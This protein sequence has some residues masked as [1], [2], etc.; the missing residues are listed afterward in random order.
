MQSST[1]IKPFSWWRLR[2]LPKILPWFSHYQVLNHFSLVSGHNLLRLLR[3]FQHDFLSVCFVLLFCY[4]WNLV[5]IHELINLMRNIFVNHFYTYG[6][7]FSLCSKN[8]FLRRYN[9]SWFFFKTVHYFCFSSSFFKLKKVCVFVTLFYP[10]RSI[11][12]LYCTFF[13]LF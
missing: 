9:A 6:K 2:K 10:L 8:S 12:H 4:T 7:I 13:V 3:G 1:L 5:F 11:T